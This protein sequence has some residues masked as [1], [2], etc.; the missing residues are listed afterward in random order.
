MIKFLQTEVVFSEIPDEVTLAIN[1]TNCCNFC[2]GCHS[3]ELRKDIGEEL[4]FEKLEELIAANDGVTCICFM[5]EGNDKHALMHLIVHMREMFG[6]KYKIGL[7]SGRNA[8]DDFYWHN[9]DYL[10]I[11][12]YIPSRGP[13]TNPNTNQKLYKIV[14][15][16]EP[17]DITYKFCQTKSLF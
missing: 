10:K 11:G 15:G 13:L 7:Y 5:G 1:I 14:Q 12:P 4:T 8:V 6:D 2:E 17:K 3:P 16:E 9:L